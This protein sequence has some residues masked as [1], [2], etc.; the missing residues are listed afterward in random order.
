MK[1]FTAEDPTMKVPTSAAGVNEGNVPLP[2]TSSQSPVKEPFT[3]KSVPS[4]EARPPTNSRMGTARRRCQGCASMILFSKLN[5][6]YF[7]PINTV[8]DG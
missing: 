5:S 4:P 3:F 7:D 1:E 2:T 6:P 8:F